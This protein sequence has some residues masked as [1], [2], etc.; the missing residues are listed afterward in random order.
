M[1]FHGHEV[2]V[3]DPEG[4]L[5]DSK[6][7][8]RVITGD[9]FFRT[10]EQIFARTSEVL[11]DGMCGGPVTFIREGKF[12]KEHVVSGMVEGIVPADPSYGLL[13]ETAVFVETGEIQKY[14]IFCIFI[15]LF[16]F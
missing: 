12:I 10:D 2:C 6:S 11:K 7:L 3:T 13:Q 4:S 1:H 5:N 9:V 16:E 14:F 15:L 8:P